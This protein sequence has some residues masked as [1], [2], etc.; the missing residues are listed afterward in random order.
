[1]NYFQIFG[2]PISGYA[3]KYNWTSGCP[4]SNTG[5]I[6]KIDGFSQVFVKMP[7]F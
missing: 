7:L 5:G 2:Y 3:E 6:P 1:M 4:K